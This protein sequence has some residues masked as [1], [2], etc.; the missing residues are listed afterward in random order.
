[1][2]WRNFRKIIFPG[3]VNETQSVIEFRKVTKRFGDVAAVADNDLSNVTGVPAYR[4][5]TEVDRAVDEA[6]AM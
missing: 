1:M 5:P 6:L 4:R 2:R 3:I